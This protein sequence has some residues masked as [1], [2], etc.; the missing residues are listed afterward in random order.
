[1]PGPSWSIDAKR[2]QAG[3]RL[4]AQAGTACSICY[5]RRGRFT[6]GPVKAANEKRLVAYYATTDW[7]AKMA[8]LINLSVTVGDPYFRWFSSGDLQ[9]EQMLI[10]ILEVCERT[11]QV[12]HW[13]P[14][15][16]RDMVANVMR[17]RPLPAN[18]TIRVSAPMING[19]TPAGCIH[20]SVV[21]GPIPDEHWRKRVLNNTDT[22]HHCPAPTHRHYECGSC[23]ACW[24]RQVETVVYK[25]K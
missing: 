2:C 5:A 20:T 8:L 22:R 4:A 6:F 1:M 15:Q 14:T 18:L 9:S 11:P 23:R 19:P 21:V 17:E 7:P 16:E 25:R 12:Y 13:L 24:S 3:S 10:D